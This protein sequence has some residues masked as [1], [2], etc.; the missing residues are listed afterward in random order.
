MTEA[1]A[2]TLD[3]GARFGHWS[4][5]EI[6]LGL[7]CYSAISLSGPFDVERD[8]V[9]RVFQPLT[10]E[11]VTVT[12]GGE[13]VLTGRVKDTAPNVDPVVKS[14]GVTAYSLASELADICPADDLLP[15]EYKGLDLRQICDRIV[16]PAIGER[17]VFEGPPGPVFS[18]VRC[19][20]DG[21]IHSFL[22]DLAVQRGF[23]LADTPAGAPLFRAEARPGAPVARLRGQPLV[24]VAVQIDPSQWYS[25]VTGRA[26]KKAGLG[27]GKR[28]TE[29]NPLYRG[30]HPRP[31]V[32]QLEDSESADVPHAVRAAIGR[33]VATVVRY[34]VDDLPTW[35]DPGGALWRPNTTVTLLAPEAMIYRETELLIR[36][37]R[38]RQTPEGE[39][40]SLD[41]TL[42]GAFGGTLPAGMPWDI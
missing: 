1:V 38:L 10:F 3:T 5:I 21:R 11:R 8:E 16:T 40:A 34:T 42:P 26:P 39:T 24:R 22:A 18:R 35:R 36:S 4:E 15:L 29:L 9:R 13:L 37:V 25:S 7:D 28:F 23:V 33:M 2:I 31:I 27:G 41:L 32:K 19:E 12:V 14:I 20:P 30:D 17:A 6:A